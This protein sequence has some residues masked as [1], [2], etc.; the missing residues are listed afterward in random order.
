[1]I[2]PTVILGGS[3][4]GGWDAPD[5]AVGRDDTAHRV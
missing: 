3:F 5:R 1:M 4:M 2:E